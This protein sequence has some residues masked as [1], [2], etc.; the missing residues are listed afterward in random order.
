MCGKYITQKEVNEGGLSKLVKWKYNQQ[1]VQNA[2][3]VIK[4]FPI[5]MKEDYEAGGKFVINVTGMNIELIN[6]GGRKLLK[7]DKKK[8]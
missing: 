8:T 6:L 4:G 2:N 3:I 7:N 5:L 1:E